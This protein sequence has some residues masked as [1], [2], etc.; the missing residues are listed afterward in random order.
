MDQKPRNV[1]TYISRSD[2]G[3]PWR[4]MPRR[5]L[6]LARHSSCPWSSPSPSS[7]AACCSWSPSASWRVSL[8]QRVHYVGMRLNKKWDADMCIDK[9]SGITSTELIVFIHKIDLLCLL[10]I[11]F[12][13]SCREME[14]KVIYCLSSDISTVTL[15]LYGLKQFLFLLL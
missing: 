11:R 14:M 1:C 10:A 5:S 15:G 13:V 8:G 12:S 4:R 9:R 6:C 3:C 7:P 2:C